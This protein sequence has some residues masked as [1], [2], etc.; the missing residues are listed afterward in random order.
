MFR[1]I[2]STM[3]VTAILFLT[4]IS[5]AASRNVSNPL[6]AYLPPYLQNP[7]GDGMTVC[8]L[9]QKE[10]ADVC[11]LWHREDD[12]RRPSEIAAKGKTVPGT[13]WIVWKARL[14]PLQAGAAYVYQVRFAQ[15]GTET[16]TP[17]CRF[18][19]MDPQA[20]VFRAAFFNDIHNRAATLEAVT[21]N[22]RPEDFEMVFLL[23][24]MWANPSPANSADEVF[25][26][27]EAYIRLLHASEKPMI[28][29]RGNHETIGG[30]AKHMAHLFDIPG[31]DASAGEFDQQWQF[32]LQAGPIWF[33]A[34]DGG[35]DF[36]K[37][38]E[39]FQPIRQRQA[40]WMKGLLARKEG[41]G[42]WRVLLTHMPLYNDNIWNSEPCR[43]MWEPILGKAAIDLELGGHDH[44]WKLLRKGT[45][46]E[47]AFNGHYPDQQDPQNR[48]R[49]SYTLPWPIM[50]GGG[51]AVKG[52]EEGAVM[53]LKADE[54]SLIVRLVGIQR[55]R[56]FPTI[57]LDTK[58]AQGAPSKG[59]IYRHIPSGGQAQ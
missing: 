5:D 25:R 55:D 53:L 30:F 24:D 27:M 22:I 3:T 49:W 57:R 18:R 35:D 21:R 38:F 20:K 40:E 37:R 59:G 33:L 1:T 8:F 23:G 56:P 36:I 10:V 2:F 45:T 44:H 6:P 13:P 39:D 41:T 31:L 17:A 15:G 9:A 54:K 43:Q 11:V 51:P 16:L 47:I 29:I 52:E 28:L 48:K 26:T 58:A 46:Y 12:A 14:V 7:T 32:T 42:C 19:S 4:G 34:L 50:V